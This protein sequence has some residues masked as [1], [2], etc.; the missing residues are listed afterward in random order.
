MFSPYLLAEPL[1]KSGAS[2]TCCQCSYLCPGSSLLSLWELNIPLGFL[3]GGS[4]GG[5]VDGS[6]GSRI[7]GS[8]GGRV[9]GSGGGRVVGGGGSG[10]VGRGG[11]GNG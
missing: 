4:G 10:I 8:C 2:P 3:P 1:L 9:D 6:G 5:R 11:S 7:D